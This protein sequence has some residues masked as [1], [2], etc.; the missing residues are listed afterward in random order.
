M[1]SGVALVIA[2]ALV[3]TG[4][5]A[6]TDAP[7]PSGEANTYICGDPGAHSIEVRDAH[8]LIDGK[9]VDSIDAVRAAIE[10]S[11][12]RAFAVTLCDCV[13]PRSGRWEVLRQ[14][15]DRVGGAIE[16]CGACACGCAAN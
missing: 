9:R 13:C 5:S 16:V 4:C 8:F 2:C 15:I 11:K 14:T 3:L 1:T 7:P 10:G 6:P 12:R